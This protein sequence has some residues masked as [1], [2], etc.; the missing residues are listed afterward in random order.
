M[1]NAVSELTD[2][3][4]CAWYAISNALSKHKR[5]QVSRAFQFICQH[6]IKKALI[7]KNCSTNHGI[8][9]TLKFLTK[10]YPVAIIRSKMM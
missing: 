4:S 2:K 8:I 10:N 6:F 5:L 7:L 1:Q 9:Y 3:A